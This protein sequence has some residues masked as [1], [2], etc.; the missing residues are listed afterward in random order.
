MPTPIYVTQPNMPPLDEFIPYLQ[1]IWDSKVVTNGGVFHKN[2]ETALCEYLGVKYLSLCS[3]GTLGLVIALKALGVKGEVITTPYSFVATAHSLLWNG[4]QPVFVDIDPETLNIDPLLIEKAITK[5]TTAIL[6]VH[7]YGRP[8]DVDAIQK[9]ADRHKLKVIYDAA[10]AFGI[11][12]SQG[13][14]LRHGEISVLSFHATKVFHTFEGGAIIS[15]D[16]RTKL[17]IDNLKNFGFLD[18]TTVIEAGINGK[19]SEINAAM[20]LLQ[21][22]HMGKA[23]ARRREV[24]SIYRAGLEG[25][26]GIRCHQTGGAS[27]SNGGYFPIFVDSNYP[28]TRDELYEK[29]RE[30]GFYA[31]RYFYP[32][33]VEFPMYNRMQSASL[34]NLANATEASKKILCLP[35]YSDISHEHVNEIIRIIKNF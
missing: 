17:H 24:D 6:A 7:C 13:S 14:L 31:R 35:I 1:K 10:H 3:N 33:I 8:C 5:N 29:L 4:L 26:V 34:N 15:S 9:I 23:L 30:D 32:L 20:G 2:L 27:K 28:V 12:D 21:L 25:V 22:P 19:M 16:E 11:E 18:E